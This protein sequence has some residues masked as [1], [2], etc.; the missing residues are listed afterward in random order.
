MSS[1]I[2]WCK[3]K[4]W[5]KVYMNMFLRKSGE[6][7]KWLSLLK[8]SFVYN[9]LNKYL[10]NQR[11]LTFCCNIEQTEM[12]GKYCIN[13][14]SKNSAQHL[15][16]FNSKKVN[17]IT[18]CDMLNEGINLND[19]QIGVYASLHSSDRLIKQ[20][21]GRLLRH[22]NPTLVIP[23]YKNTRDEEIVNIMLQ[24]YNPELVKIV[25]SPKD[26]IIE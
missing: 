17:H 25:N 15:K 26:F 21:L 14:K 13:S 23:Y 6:R 1:Y 4:N 2:E 19:C 12:L 24:D 9:L 8:T 7:L 10:P 16:M 3:R 22:P 18:A 5:M 11:T 20:Q